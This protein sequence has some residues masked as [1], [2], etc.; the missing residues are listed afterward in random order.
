MS[1]DHGSSG[2]K[3]E[4]A[5]GAKGGAGTSGEGAGSALEAMLRKRQMRVAPQPDPGAAP[6]L[7]QQDV[8]ATKE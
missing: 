8:K 5:R 2:G 1:G 3:P 4:A 7:Q 6:T